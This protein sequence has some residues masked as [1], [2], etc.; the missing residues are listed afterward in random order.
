M[1]SLEN[2]LIGLRAAESYV[3]LED[4]E[5]SGSQSIQN[6]SAFSLIYCAGKPGKIEEVLGVVVVEQK[7]CGKMA[8]ERK[9]W[10]F[11]Y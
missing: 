2:V 5:G 3:R 9:L 8:R 6:L 4:A 10:R 7:R 11:R 1:D